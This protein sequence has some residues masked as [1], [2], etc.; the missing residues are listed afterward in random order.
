MSKQ[1]HQEKHHWVP[2]TY[3]QRF[4]RNGKLT[5]ERI[6][7]HSK[8]EVFEPTPG[9]VC[10]E[11]GMNDMSKLPKDS[12]PNTPPR[13]FEDIS[14]VIDGIYSRHASESLDKGVFPSNQQTAG[15]GFFVYHLI[16]RSPVFRK[17][18]EK[19]IEN[20]QLNEKQKEIM[21]VFPATALGVILSTQGENLENAE[22]KVV[23]APE[24]E[25]FLS[26]DNPA[27]L[28]VWHRSK[29][30]LFNTHNMKGLK[31]RREDQV[32]YCPL[33]PQ[34]F[35]I[36]SPRNSGGESFSY[37]LA[38]LKEVRKLNEKVMKSAY[39]MIFR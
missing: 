31:H 12:F 38:T 24:P 35:L 8:G 1:P 23:K 27:S 26:S 18:S 20:M 11:K 34:F 22:Y 33:S 17:F 2:Q 21:N 6:S 5:A 4:T 7:G 16:A 15:F 39:T 25:R 14:G 29:L 37:H 36:F 19:A 28:W 13:L 3:L 10:C 9:S 30:R 32:I